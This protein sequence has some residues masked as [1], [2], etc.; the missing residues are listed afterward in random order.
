MKMGT[1][2]MTKLLAIKP[3][4]TTTLSAD[5]FKTIPGDKNAWISAKKYFGA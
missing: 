4:V 2:L 3:H 5:F 1:K